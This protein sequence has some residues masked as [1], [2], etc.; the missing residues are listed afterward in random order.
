MNVERLTRLAE[1]LEAQKFVAKAEFKLDEWFEADSHENFKIFGEAIETNEGEMWQVDPTSI[2]CGTA[3]CACG[4]AAM[5]PEFQAEGL[6]LLADCCD[7]QAVPYF[8]GLTGW[9][10]VQKFFDLEDHEAT[11]L[12]TKSAYVFSDQAGEAADVAKRIRDFIKEQA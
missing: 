8:D 7:N 5:M 4:H 12:F 6:K 2:A 9:L 10:A 1:V 3:A 11:E